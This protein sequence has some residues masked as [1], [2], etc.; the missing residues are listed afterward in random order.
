MLLAQ[1]LALDVTVPF[2]GAYIDW[3]KVLVFGSNLVAV[4]L[5][6]VVLLYCFI[7]LL[8]WLHTSAL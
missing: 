8:S 2:K 1:R 6:P 5:P 3:N 7:S 4:N